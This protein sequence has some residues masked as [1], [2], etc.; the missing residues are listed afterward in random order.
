MVVAAYGLILPPTVLASPGLGCVNVHASLLP[1]WRGAAPI[2]R[3]LLA[4]DTQ[5]GVSIMRMEQGLDTGPVLGTAR[6]P[7]VPAMTGGELHD[8]LALLGAET[9]IRLLPALAAGTLE[10]RPQDDELACYAPKL[11]KADAVLDWSRPAAELER[12]VLALNP[13]PVAQTEAGDRVLRIW[14]ART[15][16]GSAPASSP[17]SVIEERRDGIIVATGSGTL[18]LTEVQLSGGRP[19]PIADFLNA[20]T[21]HGLTLGRT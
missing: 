12:Q 3:A 7:I 17:G 21:L 13:W 19:M 6:C 11:E 18:S 1:R 16:T 10:A 20:H 9:L 2:Q 15:I 4:G 14:R 5:T 8:R